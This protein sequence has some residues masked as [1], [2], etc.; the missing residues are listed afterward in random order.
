MNETVTHAAMEAEPR[1][2]WQHGWREVALYLLPALVLG[3]VVRLVPVLAADFPLND[4]GL[5]LAMM[6]DIERAGFILPATTT[7]NLDSI[8]FA[9]PP[10]ALYQ[11]AGLMAIGLDPVVL[12]R[13]IP[14][15]LSIAT[16]PLVY[17]VAKDL[18]G[19]W[20]TAG[21][22]ALSFALL[23]RSYEWLIT[24]GGITRSLGMLFALLAIWQGTRLIVRASPLRVV[25]TGVLGGLTL[26]THPEASIF[27]V[28]TL[29]VFL[30]AF[31]RS[32][33]ALVSVAAAGGIGLLVA[34][35]WWVSVIGAHGP[36]ALLGAAGSRSLVFAHVLR[37]FV[38]G[39]FTGA[40]ALDIFLGIGFVGL[41]IQFGRRRYLLPLW[42]VSVVALILGAGFTFAT[43]PWAMLTAVAIVEVILPAASRLVRVPDRGR[44]VVASGLLGAGVLASLAT[45]Y[46]VSSPIHG[47]SVEQREAMAWVKANV[48][49]DAQFVV[50]TGTEWWLDATSEWFPALARRESLATVQG[51]EWTDAFL[52]RAARSNALQDQC[53]RR[54]ATCLDSWQEYFDVRVDYVYLAN[55]RL[56]GLASP[57]DCCPAL[58]ADL[59]RSF[60]VVYEG[61]GATIIR[62]PE[63]VT[64]TH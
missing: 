16:I 9:Y 62:W 33:R 45:G 57:D 14:V 46:G 47:L 28:V 64:E 50:V 38:F 42:L 22:A 56:A 49:Q 43:V 40:S 35:P 5:F 6:E 37:D 48:P 17:V 4:G 51:Y 8:P 53:A 21:V 32:R 59:R 63:T 11:G 29:A 3:A 34:A 58:R 26:L 52:A 13:V 20:L 39:Q 54:L 31:G 2:S 24:G 25:L 15:V 1:R 18:L 41:L 61:D 19:S 55:G 60:E 10:L 7:Y 30:L 36:D 23:P 27:V 12:L 44:F